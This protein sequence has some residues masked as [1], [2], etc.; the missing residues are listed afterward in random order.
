VV[1]PLRFKSDAVCFG[2]CAIGSA[3]VTA[4]RWLGGPRDTTSRASLAMLDMEGQLGVVDLPICNLGERSGA[5]AEPWWTVPTNLWLVDLKEGDSVDLHS[6]AIPSHGGDVA[7]LQV[8]DCWIRMS[9]TAVEATTG[10]WRS[11][12]VE[13]IATHITVRDL[14][15]LLIC[16]IDLRHADERCWLAP[17]FTHTA[18]I[19]PSKAELGFIAALREGDAVD[20]EVEVALRCCRAGG[21]RAAWRRQQRGSQPKPIQQRTAITHY[22][23]HATSGGNGRVSASAGHARRR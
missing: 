2:G 8:E 10:E 22:L 6:R 9:V 14:S 1:P 11:T 12:V 7:L 15:D 5:E 17:A 4:L 20:V 16:A 21:R 13:R 3:V 18:H 19:V 23:H